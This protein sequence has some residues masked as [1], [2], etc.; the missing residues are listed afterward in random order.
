MSISRKDFLK[1]A[2]SGGVSTMLGISNFW[3][4]DGV[5][6][7]TVQ[8]QSLVMGSVASFTV[9]AESEKDG[10]AAIRKGVEVF[11]RMDSIFSMYKTDSEMMKLSEQSGKEPIKISQDA[12]KLLDKAKEFY[13]K[14]NGFFDVTIE[15]AM[16]RWGFRN[17]NQ[18]KV[19][20]PTD[21]ELQKIESLIG[22]DK[23]IIED[24][25]A[26]LANRGMAI[27]TGGIA[28]G[29]ALDKAIEAMKKCDI[30]AAFINFSGDI[31]CFGEP[32]EGDGW[33]VQ[34]YNPITGQPLAEAVTLQNRALSTSG[35]YQNRREGMAGRSW[36][37]LLQPGSAIPSE[38]VASLTAIHSSAMQADAWSTAVYIGAAPPDD[39]QTIIIE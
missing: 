18:S 25:S 11:R 10:Y 1:I 16:R 5:K 23:L 21:E 31:H 36:G 24:D 37:H 35:A 17:A 39:L 4:R 27:D 3:R 12:Q 6:L 32:L 7:T 22:S 13:S 26:L 14:T 15:P 20:A 38:P 2:L 9:V 33:K 30:A 19:D 28:G 29:Y 34:I 8:R